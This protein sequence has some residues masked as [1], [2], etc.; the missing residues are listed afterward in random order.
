[1]HKLIRVSLL[2]TLLLTSCSAS[3]FSWED[4]WLRADQQGEKAMNE[5]NA[6]KAASLFKSHKW[7]G[8][9]NYRAGNYQHAINNFSQD[10]SADGYYNQGNTLAQI[11]EYQKAL[12]AYNKALKENPKMADAQYNKSVIEK[13]LK[14]QPK[15]KNDSSKSSENQKPQ[16]NKNKQSQH[17]QSDK[18]QKQ[19]SPQQQQK[20]SQQKQSHSQKQQKTEKQ[21][22]ETQQSKSTQSAQNK[23]SR[24][25]KPGQASQSVSEQKQAT[26]QWLRGIPDN[27]GGL[28]QQKFLRDHQNY[29]ALQQQ[30]KQPW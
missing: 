30:G 13:M 19:N 25:N 24:S 16:K 8:V 11:G 5:G 4:L 14:Q 29:Q 23:S 2:T 9:A 27:P 18:S 6:K 17:A 10:K 21:Q 15:Q 12:D 7:Q 26:E 3:A 1:M 22:K 28:L 20:N